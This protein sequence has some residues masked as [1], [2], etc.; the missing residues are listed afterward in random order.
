[1]EWIVNRAKKGY[2]QDISLILTYGSYI[3]GTA[4]PKSDV[5]CYFIPKTQRGYEFATTL[6][7]DGIGYDIFP[8][9]WERVTKIANL[10]QVLL[11]CVGDVK[12][13][14]AASQEDLERFRGL[15][16][17]MGKNLQDEAY[18][19]Q[20]AAEKVSEAAAMLAGNVWVAAG[21]IICTLADAVA[22]YNHTYYHRGMKKQYED[23]LALPGIPSEIPEEYLAVIRSK[24]DEECIEHCSR[25]LRVVADY[26][27]VEAE[28]G[29]YKA[30]PTQVWNYQELGPLYEEI[31]STFNK[32]YANDDPVVVYHAAVSLQGELPEDL[33]IIGAYCYEDLASIKERA[34]LVEQCYVARILEAGGQIN[35]Y[36]TMEEV[37]RAYD[38]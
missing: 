3:N 5:D 26:I 7:L 8:V 28:L 27:G 37:I 33:D 17:R 25:M 19:R 1:M 10:K 35:R 2:A 21:Y 30:Q 36:K 11:P 4:G 23:L 38:C 20:I 12:V 14:Y 16:E 18:S 13:L 9:S 22:I 34:K 15:Q 6:I 31:S 32:I 29:E 24:T